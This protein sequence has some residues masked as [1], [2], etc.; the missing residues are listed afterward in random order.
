MVPSQPHHSQASSIRDWVI[1][2]EKQASHRDSL[3]YGLL[4]FPLLQQRAEFPFNQPTYFKTIIMQDP[5]DYLAQL[6][7]KLTEEQSQTDPEGAPETG[8]LQPEQLEQRMM[9]SGS[10]IAEAF[11]APEQ[12]DVAPAD[13]M[14]A[15]EFLPAECPQHDDLLVDNPMPSQ[16]QPSDVVILEPVITLTVITLSTAVIAWKHLQ[17]A[18]AMTF[19]KA[20]A[21]T[22][23]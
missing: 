2:E 3:T 7:N 11:D 6:K 12:M 8:K 21:A 4:E 1:L 23:C 16:P 13:S 18:K 10:Q 14:P 5:K 9:L 20:E 22:T 15:Q 19:S 17:V